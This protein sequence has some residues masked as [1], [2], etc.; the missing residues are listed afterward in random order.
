MVKPTKPKRKTT[1]PRATSSKGKGKGAKVKPSKTPIPK[2]K[3]LSQDPEAVRSRRRRA[4]A[5]QAEETRRAAERRARREQQGLADARRAERAQR[6]PRIPK[7]TPR[8]RKPA[9]P[10]KPATAKPIRPTRKRPA[11]G[12]RKPSK[13]SKPSKPK[14]KPRKPTRPTRPPTT[15]VATHGVDWL[16]YMRNIAASV[17]PTSLDIV[18]PEAASRGVAVWAIVGRF[19]FLDECDYETLAEI[20]NLWANDLPLEVAINPQRMSQIRIVFEDPHAKRGEGDSIVSQMGAWQFVVADLIGEIVGGGDDDEDA[21]ATRY[22][23]TKI[24]RIYVYFSEEIL[25]YST[26]W[27]GGPATASIGQRKP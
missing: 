4:A 9:K 26:A 16:E 20:L 25:N 7:P 18:E 12:R 10:S 14:R 1:T 6:A 17:V 5:K 19:E 15:S 13:P 11:P 3:R 2:A 21:L 27:G 23:D 22:A 8:R 24:P